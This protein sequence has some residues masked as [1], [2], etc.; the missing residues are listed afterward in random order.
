[1]YKRV[2]QCV[3]VGETPET[4][5]LVET[6]THLPSWYPLPQ[7]RDKKR[8]WYTVPCSSVPIGPD[9]WTERF[10]GTEF[11]PKWKHTKGFK[12]QQHSQATG[13]AEGE[14]AECVVEY[15]GELWIPCD[16]AAITRHKQQFGLH[17]YFK[18]VQVFI[19]VSPN[20]QWF[21]GFAKKYS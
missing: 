11:R 18:N 17:M 12:T 14:K 13:G 6:E 4:L 9:C 3:P 16:A 1:M 19:V 5:A 15:S 7:A 8:R 2:Q 20:N 21:S 10:R